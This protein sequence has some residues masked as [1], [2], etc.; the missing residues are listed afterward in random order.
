M[1]LLTLKPSE[2]YKIFIHSKS[3]VEGVVNTTRVQRE[4]IPSYTFAGHN[5]LPFEWA[6]DLL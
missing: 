2:K 3:M 5:L 6:L 4:D 1:Y